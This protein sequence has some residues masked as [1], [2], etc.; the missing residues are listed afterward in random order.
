MNEKIIC[1]IVVAL[2]VASFGAG[3][4]FSTRTS[5]RDKA[6]I[7]ELE[8]SVDRLT[9]SL[10]DATARAD[11]L[12]RELND[13]RELITRSSQELARS[14]QELRKVNERIES[15]KSIAGTIDVGVTDSITTV[16]R[17]IKKIELLELSL[18]DFFSQ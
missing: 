4:Y 1:F 18:S 10:R 14:E 16:D 13:S 3:L 11:S 6:R 12:A 17:I 8:E 7:I 2:C 5:S 9:T 15:A